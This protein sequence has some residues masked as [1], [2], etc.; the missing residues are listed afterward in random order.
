AH[1][2]AVESAHPGI[3]ALS[4][5]GTSYEGRALWAAKISDN[6]GTDENEPEVLFDAV[7][8]AREHLTTEMALYVLDLLAGQYG[9]GS[10]LGQRVT[11]LVDAREVWIVFMLNPDGLQ[12]D[13]TGNPYRLWRKNRQPTPNSSSIGTDLNR[14][15]GYRWGCCGG[16]S[17]SPGSDTYRGPAP[18]SA[19]EVAAFRDF[20]KS[21]VV[22]GRQ[23]I[24]AHITFHTSAELILYP[25]GYTHDKVPADMTSADHR[26]FIDLADA[27]AATNGYTAMQSSSLYITDG[28]QI[29]WMYATQRIFS[30]TFEMYPPADGQTTYGRF[31]PPDEQIAPQTTRNREAVLYLLD[32]ADCPYRASGREAELCGPFFDDLEISRGWTVDPS[33]TD[34][35]TDGIWK[36][37]IPKAGTYQQPAFSG[38]GALTTGLQGGH[39]V[40]GGVTTVRSPRVELPAGASTL[41]LR[42]WVGLGADA[43]SNDRFTIRLV[44]QS[45]APVATALTVHGDRARHAAKWRTLTFPIPAGLQGT[46]VA[47]E[48]VASDLGLDGTLE[49]GVDQVRITAP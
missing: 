4:Q 35:A 39:D 10:A 14:N 24:R 32:Q 9:E 2:Q 15:Y 27:M 5:I 43:R 6:V 38:Q 44:D 48:L 31:Y 19:P 26:T 47:I 23:Q 41:R 28:D 37:G 40:D 34:S 8:H 21:R 20:V 33:G 42:Y 18:W 7:H 45:G 1:I 30:F 29:D 46:D 22:G 3:V 49:A 13:L 25:Y 36:R 17:G 16:S 12:F 11:G